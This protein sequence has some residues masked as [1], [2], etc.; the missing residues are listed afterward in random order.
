MPH[1]LRAMT[2]ILSLAFLAPPLRISRLYPK[3]WESTIALETLTHH[4]ADC[5]ETDNDDDDDNN[6]NHDNNNNDDDDDDERKKS[7][8]LSPGYRRCR[9]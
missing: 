6:K 7:W 9:V 5:Q 8:P 1:C 4:C 2:P 3:L